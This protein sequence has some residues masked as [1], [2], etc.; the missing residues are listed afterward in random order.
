MTHLEVA[1]TVLPFHFH[2]HRSVPRN[3]LTMSRSCLL[4]TLGEHL[5]GTSFPNS[6]IQIV[7]RL[8]FIN[9]R[10]SYSRTLVQLIQ[11][12]NT[13]GI[14]SVRSIAPLNRFHFAP[15]SASNPFLGQRRC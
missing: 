9:T 13:N 10:S 14:T 4:W 2:F 8:L 7:G 12:V 6:K 1:L 15:D 11:N 5:A 3:H